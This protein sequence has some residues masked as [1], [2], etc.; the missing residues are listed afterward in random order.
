MDLSLNISR[1]F[2]NATKSKNNSFCQAGTFDLSDL[3]SPWLTFLK[4]VLNIFILCIT[5]VIPHTAADQTDI[6]Y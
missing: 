6:R 4:S 3:R 1:S 5:L 2:S